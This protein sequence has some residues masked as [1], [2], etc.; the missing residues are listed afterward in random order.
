MTEIEA[1]KK[2][3]D[4][5]KSRLEARFEDKVDKLKRGDELP[6]LRVLI[7]KIVLVERRTLPANVHRF[8][9]HVPRATPSAIRRALLQRS[10]LF[11]IT[12][13]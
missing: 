9:H 7:Q 4:E 5:S 11:T 12:S 8:Q 10:I 6:L 13:V 2:Q 1:L 3:Y